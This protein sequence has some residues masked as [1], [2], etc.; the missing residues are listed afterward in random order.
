M[1]AV[2]CETSRKFWLL[3]QIMS[4][5]CVMFVAAVCIVFLVKLKWPKNKSVYE[6][7][8][9]LESHPPLQATLNE[10]I[11]PHIHM[12]L[13]DSPTANLSR[14]ACDGWEGRT[15][16]WGC[17]RG[18]ARGFARRSENRVFHSVTE[19]KVWWC[20]AGLIGLSDD[21]ELVIPAWTPA[22]QQLWSW[23]LDF[24][25]VETTKIKRLVKV[26]S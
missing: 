3:F 13:G 16:V 15:F 8:S 1:C 21:S 20:S 5:S 17:V 14:A 26:N 25:R 10:D 11:F 18:C 7:S 24:P 12:P 23:G 2:A 22:V 19:V 6:S 9:W 4:S